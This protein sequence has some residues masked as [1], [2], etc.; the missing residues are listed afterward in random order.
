MSEI[1]ASRRGQRAEN[2]GELNLEE[3]FEPCFAPIGRFFQYILQGF[4]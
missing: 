1:E 3:L 4:K 2:L